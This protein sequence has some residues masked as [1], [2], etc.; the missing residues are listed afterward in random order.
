MKD[1]EAQEKVLKKLYEI[2][3]DYR[4]FTVGIY[5]A[6]K[7]IGIDDVQQLDQVASQLKEKGLIEIFGTSEKRE[8]GRQVRISNY[9]IEYVEK[10]LL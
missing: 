8:S 9:G 4:G 10:S 2:N 1:I 3:R 7:E 5:D 6:G